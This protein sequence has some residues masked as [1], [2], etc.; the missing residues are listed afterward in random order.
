M[1]Q[2]VFFA[3]AILTATD[4]RLYANPSSLSESVRAYLTSNGVTV[5]P[6]E[7]FWSSL[8]QWAEQVRMERAR[9][10][11]EHERDDVVMATNDDKMDAAAE[12]ESEDEQDKD[13]KIVKTDK[14]L[15]GNRTSWA[16]ARAIGEVCAS[17]L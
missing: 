11:G 12:K 6:Y 13:E 16:I 9:L 7:Q 5:E 3:Y 17:V 8:G 15:I 1:L 4:C 2:Q 10:A 14:V